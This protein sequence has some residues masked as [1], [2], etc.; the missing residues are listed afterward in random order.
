M[1]KIFGEYVFIYSIFC[2]HDFYKCSLNILE[3]IDYKVKFSHMYLIGD[4]IKK[5]ILQEI[6]VV[7]DFPYVFSEDL[8][9]LPPNREVEFTIELQPK[10]QPI[11]K[12]PY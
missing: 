4:G 2:N 10:I 5:T 11:F 8:P 6:P 1:D 7:K 12:A 3:C 9:R